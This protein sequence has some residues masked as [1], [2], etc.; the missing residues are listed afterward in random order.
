MS[1]KIKTRREQL[2]L[3]QKEVADRLQI[4]ESAY[5]RYEQDKSEPAV[6]RAIA[7]AKVL[8]TTVDKLY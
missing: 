7:I 5:Q 8:K 2:N 3:T 1:N 4:A 6:R